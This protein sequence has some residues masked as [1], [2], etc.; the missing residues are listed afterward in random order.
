MRCCFEVHVFSFD[1]ANPFE[2]PDEAKVVVDFL[3]CVAGVFFN[4]RRCF[5]LM[6]TA[7]WPLVC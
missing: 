2:T 6:T 1:V 4:C 3:L 7:V 5:S